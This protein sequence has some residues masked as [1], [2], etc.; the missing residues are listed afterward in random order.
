MGSETRHITTG[1]LASC[2]HF[3]AKDAD[4]FSPVKKRIV[5]LSE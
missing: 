5:N 1:D 4:S 3:Y 2:V